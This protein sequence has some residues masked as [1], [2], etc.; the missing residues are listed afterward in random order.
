MDT[1]LLQKFPFILDKH[2]AKANCTGN[3]FCTSCD[4]VVLGLSLITKQC[5]RTYHTLFLRA[6]VIFPSV[7]G[8]DAD[9]SP[10]NTS[11]RNTNHGKE[12]EELR[13]IAIQQL[14]RSLDAARTVNPDAVMAYVASVSSH[15][16]KKGHHETEQLVYLAKST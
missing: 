6:F 5:L 9:H 8:L 12:F 7:S 4:K 15:L 2:L 14:C 11:T 1:T 10:S 13:D 16:L 3:H